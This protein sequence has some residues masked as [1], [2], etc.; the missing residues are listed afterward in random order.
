MLRAFLPLLLRASDLGLPNVKFH[1]AE[2]AFCGAQ[3]VCGD[4][5]KFAVRNLTAGDNELIEQESI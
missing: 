3:T 1:M 4:N 5:L 2:E